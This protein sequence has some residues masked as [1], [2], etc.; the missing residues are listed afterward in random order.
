MVSV[1]KVEKGVVSVPETFSE[2]LSVQFQTDPM[3]VGSRL[4]F[5]SSM[6]VTRRRLTVEWDLTLALSVAM[7]ML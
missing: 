2:S 5:G 7:V 6:G 4:A 1:G 3:S